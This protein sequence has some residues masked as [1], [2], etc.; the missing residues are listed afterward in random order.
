MTDKIEQFEERGHLQSHTARCINTLEWRLDYRTKAWGKN[1][2]HSLSL[3][4][5]MKPNLDINASL[6]MLCSYGSIII[7]A[8][9]YFGT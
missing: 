7:K 8:H 1:R 6:I 2:L 9:F 5:R 3:Y 4:S